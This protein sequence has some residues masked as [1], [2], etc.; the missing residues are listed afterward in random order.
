MVGPGSVQVSEIDLSSPLNYGTP[1]S[2]HSGLSASR[3]GSVR[4][5]P[6]QI[7]ADIQSERRLRQVELTPARSG[8]PG[9]GSV[10]GTPSGPAG[11][12]SEAGSTRGTPRLGGRRSSQAPEQPPSEAVPPSENSENAP[13]L[14]IWGTDVSVTACKT[15]FKKFLATFVEANAEE[16]ERMDGF[17]SDEPLYLQHLAEVSYFFRA[18]PSYAQSLQK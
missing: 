1:A 4:G 5:T 6:I 7:R 8:Q 13:N 12:P 16:D 9:G 10:T 2:A 18:G 17:R 11:P 3:Q 14:V 15:K